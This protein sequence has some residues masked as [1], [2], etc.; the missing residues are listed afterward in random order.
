VRRKTWIAY[1][2]R[3]NYGKAGLELMLEAIGFFA[4]F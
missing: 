1:L 3:G 4:A 2:V